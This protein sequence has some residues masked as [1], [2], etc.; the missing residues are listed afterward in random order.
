MLML[1]QT[2]AQGIKTPSCWMLIKL[3]SCFDDS[4]GLFGMMVY[5]C[6]GG[7]V[8]QN[9]WMVC[10]QLWWREKLFCSLFSSCTT[11]PEETS[12]TISKLTGMW[13][14]GGRVWPKFRNQGYTFYGHTMIKYFEQLNKITKGYLWNIMLCSAFRQFLFKILLFA[15]SN[16]SVLY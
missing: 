1:V 10:P 12:V 13:V 11:L 8:Q 7:K 16:I 6:K 5:S 2:T 15:L 3:P 4:F 14:G 9:S